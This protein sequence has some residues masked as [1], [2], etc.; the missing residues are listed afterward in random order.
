MRKRQKALACQ[1]FFIAYCRPFCEMAGETEG[2]MFNRISA[3]KF[4]TVALFCGFAGA[5][6]SADEKPRPKGAAVL[7]IAGKTAHWNRGAMVPERDS[8]MK[9][10][11]IRFERAMT[12]DSEMLASL[13]QHE[14]RVVTPAGE[15]TYSGPLLADVLKASG[16][17]AGKIRL[18]G[19]DGSDSELKPEEV[20][21]QSWILALV[22]D[23]KPV[24][25]GD[26]GPLWLMHKPNAGPAPS[27]EEMER[28]VW[29]L[30]YIEVQ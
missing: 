21:G 25:I 26:F 3:L 4:V 15:G 5:P 19:L 1:G 11:D 17:E 8:L 12:F 2:K 18:L 16:A 6:V 9:Q 29:S 7:T 10:R 13:P 24:G 23:G 28:W 20:A 30:F 22:V 14:L 27:R